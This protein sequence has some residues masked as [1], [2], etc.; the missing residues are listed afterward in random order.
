MEN[1]NNIEIN[2]NVKFGQLIIGP[3]GCGKTTY[4]QS[5]KNYYSNYNRKVLLINLDPAN[6]TTNK[7]FDIDIRDLINL[8]EVEK[9]LSLGPNSSFLYCF[10][11]LEKNFNWLENK[12]NLYKDIYYF[13]I[14]TPGQ[15]EI[16]TLSDS[17]K[18]ICKNLTN[19]KKLNIRLCAVNLIECINLCDMP[20]YIFS[21]FSVLNCMINLELPQINLISKCDLLKELKKN[22]KFVFDIEFYKNP[23]NSEQLNFFLDNINEN[24][25]FKNLNKVISEFISDFGLV[26]F[27]LLDI[28]N[29]NHL[30][31][32][33]ILADKANGLLYYTELIEKE[34]QFDGRMLVASDDLIDEEKCDEEYQ[35]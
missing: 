18:T 12:I 16:F 32:A 6:E 11:F 26:S 27:S 7:I 30:N 17:F 35:I 29:V 31:R 21:V 15:I 3:P 19:E 14:D 1:I 8:D 20:K 4:I 13:L 9:N 34:E 2:S 23:N 24:P 10:N 33:A 5:M 28:S 22:N 25:K